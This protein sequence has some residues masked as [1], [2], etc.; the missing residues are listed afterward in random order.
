MEGADWSKSVVTFWWT[1]DWGFPAVIISDREP[2]F[3]QGLWKG[4][5]MLL[6]VDLF[7]TTTYH[8]QADGIGTRKPIPLSASHRASTWSGLKGPGNKPIF[9]GLQVLWDRNSKFRGS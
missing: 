1:A 5:F 8:P 7:Y 9:W 3:T 2:K 4:I 6:Q